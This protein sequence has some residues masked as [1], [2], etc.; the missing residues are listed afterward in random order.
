MLDFVTAPDIR[1]EVVSTVL[2]L[3]LMVGLGAGL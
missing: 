1:A 3:A 2:L